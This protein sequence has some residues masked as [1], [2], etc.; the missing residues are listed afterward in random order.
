MKSFSS[1]SFESVL[2][3]LRRF[4]EN[5]RDEVELIECHNLAP[6]EEGLE[7]HS[8]ISDVTSAEW[9]IDFTYESLYDSA[10]VLI[11]GSEGEPVEV[12]L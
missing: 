8:A 2:V 5:A 10:G 11:E 9:L 1:K 3:G 4:S 7:L 6:A 12:A